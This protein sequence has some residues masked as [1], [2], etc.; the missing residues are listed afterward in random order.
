MSSS[1]VLTMT[2]KGDGERC[3]PQPVEKLLTAPE[4]RIY[5]L[6]GECFVKLSK[7]DLHIIMSVDRG[8]IIVIYV[9]IYAI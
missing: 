3:V 5:Y 2:L 6:F 8:K 4:T 9:V 7:D 1:D